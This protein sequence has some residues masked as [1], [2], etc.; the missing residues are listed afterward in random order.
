[1][2]SIVHFKD[3]LRFKY[4]QD[5]GAY[6]RHHN[7]SDSEAHSTTGSNLGLEVPKH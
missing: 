2:Q 4:V 1:M 6:I 7:A 3:H 5:V